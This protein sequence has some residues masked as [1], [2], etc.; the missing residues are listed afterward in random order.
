M[1]L[2][3]RKVG[4]LVAVL[5]VGPAWAATYT[6]KVR[7]QPSSD[8][9][10]IGY[11][12]YTRVASGVYG[13]PQDAGKP[14]PAADGTMSFLVTGLDS[15]LIHAFAVTDY[16]SGGIES[17]RSNELTLPAQIATTTT[18]T[19]RATST[20]TTTSRATTTST[21]RG[22]TS[23]T[24]TTTTTT[25]STTARR[26]ATT[27]T[28]TSP[29]TASSCRSTPRSGCQPAAARKALLLLGRGRLKW[30]WTSA[31]PVDVSAFGTPSTTT[32]YLVCIYDASGRKLS[33]LAP[34]GGVCRVHPCWRTL[35]SLGFR[36]GDKDGLPDGLT[37]ILLAAGSAGRARIQVAGGPA[38][39]PDPGMPL[40]TPV[41]VQF[42]RTDGNACW[43]ARY[44]TASS[45][46]P[47]GFKAKSD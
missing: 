24:R 14:T 8:A 3:S 42:Q 10:V 34:A 37:Q 40:T 4:W 27:T 35:G 2:E 13:T 15:S 18:T 28:T 39:F 33:A 41:R 6:A 44:G 20:T 7:W 29:P 32:N 11:R 31:D 9:R 45:N 43:E 26:S 19:T 47:S 38:N 16:V 30:R 12:V 1:L 5:W 23:T 22:T 36:Y 21:S 46:T 17:S 25:T